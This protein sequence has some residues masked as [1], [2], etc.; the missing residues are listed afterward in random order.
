VWSLNRES[1]PPGSSTTPNQATGRNFARARGP[2][3]SRRLDSRSRT[4][5]PASNPA[6]R[7]VDAGI[8]RAIGGVRSLPTPWFFNR[9]EDLIVTLELALAYRRQPIQVTTSQ[10]QGQD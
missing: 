2:A 1:R 6:Q 10:R 5:N 8:E 4:D 3:S 7:S 9:Y